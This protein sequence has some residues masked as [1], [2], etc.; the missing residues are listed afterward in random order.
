MPKGPFSEKPDPTA[1]PLEA[2]DLANVA[3]EG[4]RPFMK[5]VSTGH[6]VSSLFV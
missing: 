3:A 4:E 5:E 6:F 2:K 1:P